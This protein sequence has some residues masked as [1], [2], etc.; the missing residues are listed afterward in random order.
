MVRAGEADAFRP[1]IA[2][3][4]DAI[5]LRRS[6]SRVEKLADS[7]VA[8][9]WHEGLAEIAENALDQLHSQAQRTLEQIEAARV[10]VIRP[11]TDNRLARMLVLALG[12][13]TAHEAQEVSSVLAATEAELQGSPSEEHRLIALRRAG[14]VVAARG[15]IPEFELMAAAARIYGALPDRNDERLEV[16]D[17]AAR[18][19]AGLVAND[20][21]RATTR[22][23]AEEL[24]ALACSGFP[25][26]KSALDDLLDEPVSDVADDDDLWVATVLGA[27][28]Y[29][30][31]VP[32]F[33]G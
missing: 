6:P 12:L 3:V 30:A 13:R 32:A 24:A 15:D 17:S 4:T 18:A 26:L 5:L 11:V 10:E 2:P 19:L 20:D 7:A 16:A 28:S 33:W 1:R 8:A 21:R 25:L 9:V 31:G 29:T 22:Q 27:L 14:A 23:A